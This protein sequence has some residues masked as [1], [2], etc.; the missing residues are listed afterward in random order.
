MQCTHGFF[1]CN[2]LCTVL[3]SFLDKD[4]Q[5]IAVELYVGTELHIGADAAQTGGQ[6]AHCHVHFDADAYA[7]NAHHIKLETK[8]FIQQIHFTAAGSFGTHFNPE[9][10]PFSYLVFQI[11][12]DGQ[13][14]IGMYQKIRAEFHGHDTDVK[15][16][17]EQV[18]INQCDPVCLGIDHFRIFVH[19]LFQTGLFTG[20]IF[21]CENL[22]KFS[23]DIGQTQT[24][25][26]FIN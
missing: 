6:D 24:L 19:Q 8:T 14:E 11:G 22:F 10:V 20:F 16:L 7:H 13:V 21:R 5:E 1:F 3:R 15:F 4:I 12:T 26:Y 9:I 2:P 18:L 23:A 25:F 17:L